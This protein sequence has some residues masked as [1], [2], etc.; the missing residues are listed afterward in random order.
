MTDTEACI[1]LN[2]VPGIGPVRLR[3][4]LSRFGSPVDVLAA[5]AEALLEVPG[6]GAEVA[7]SIASW[8][9]T[10]RLEEELARIE[11]A[12]VQVLAWSSPDYP[13][14][15]RE[16]HDAPIVLHVLGAPPSRAVQS[17][18]VVGTRKPS[19]YAADCAKKLSY[20][21]ATAGITIIS[22]LARGV[23]TFAHQAALAAKGRTFA[24][25]GSGLGKIY[26]PENRELATRIAAEGGTVISEFSM[27]QGA[28][29]QTF[30]MRNRIISG[31]SFGILVVEAGVRSGALITA[32]Q[33]AEQGR[34]IYAVPGRIDNPN[35]IGSNK[36]IQQGAKLVLSAAD[37]L[38]DFSI[39]FKENPR[40]EPPPIPADPGTPESKILM[41]LQADE[42]TVDEIIARSG[43]LPHQVSAAL[44]GLEIKGLVRNLPGSR[45]VRLN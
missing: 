41:A 36:L 18:G 14:V 22:G 39:L 29:K 26:P 37:I 32:N 3:R 21:L 15:L 38:D 13:A 25:I 19:H 45:F 24:V 44:L 33:A 6:I 2:M 17:I 4:L 28:D 10:L 40:L 31:L 1:A 12:G 27:L 16:I 5:S 20:Q 23:D 11:K 7:S 43:L 34:S 35:A 30:P 9:Q 8:E 42:L